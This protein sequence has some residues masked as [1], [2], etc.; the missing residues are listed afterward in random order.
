MTSS[1]DPDQTVPI[2]AVWSGS[3][4]FA[5]YKFVSNVRHLFAAEDILKCL[6][7]LSFK[8]L[9]YIF[10]LASGDF[11]RL[12]INFTNSLGPDDLW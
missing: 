2:G 10:F 1:V 8:G 11:C 12:L 9:F 6:F 5:F 3:M 7:S 4:L